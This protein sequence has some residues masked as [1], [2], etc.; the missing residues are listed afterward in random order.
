MKEKLNRR[1]HLLIKL[2]A[3]L[4]WCFIPISAYS[5]ER[6]VTGRVIDKENQEPIP[7]VSIV[8]E[9][10]S[11]GTITDMDGN[12][13]LEVDGPDTKMTFSFIGFEAQTVEVGTQQQI[14]ISLRPDIVDLD[15]V[16]VVGYGT[17]KKRD[18]TGAVASVKGSSMDKGSPVSM[19]SALAGRVAGVQVTQTDNGPGAGVK[20]LIRGGSTLTGGNQPLYVIDGFP[21]VPDDSNPN[22]NPLADLNPND[23]ESM[24]ILKDASSTAIYGAEGANG[25]II[26]TT[27]LGKA[28]RPSI[29]VN[30]SYGL[31]EMTNV[32][33]ILSPDE[34][35]NW[36]IEKGP[37][38]QFY[39]P[40]VY[41]G[42]WQ[43][44]KDSG[45]PGN[46][47]ID[48]IT[49]QGETHKA[50]VSFSGGS[51][52]M[53]YRLS[54]SYLG[55]EGVL[56]NS[57]FERFNLNANLEQEI[58]KRIKIG[59]S[60][61]YSKAESNGMVNSWDESAVVK[62][63][64]QINPFMPEDY[65]IDQIDEEAET[66]TW[67]NENVLTYMD[68]VDI[69]SA[70]ERMIG[71]MFFQYKIANGLNFYT[72]YGLNSFSDDSHEFYPSSVRRGYRVGGFANFRN[73]K[74][75]NT[76]YQARFNFNKRVNDHSF[77]VTTVFEAKKF[78]MTDKRFGAEGFEDESRGV[79]DLSSVVTPY[80]PSNIYSDNSMMSYMGRL[81]Y[82]YKGK[83]LLTASFRAD[84]SS[85][86]GENNKWGY[87]PSAAI[88]WLASEEGF[89]KD[90]NTFDLLKLRLSYGVTGNN[91]I[92]TYQSLANLSTEKY[93]FDESVYVGMVPGRIANPDLKW[94]TTQQY[95]VGMDLGFF[96]NRLLV[97]AE[98]YYKET[99]D[100]LLEVQ[101]PNTSG[102]NTAI[103]N[104]GSISNKGFELAINTVNIDNKDFKWTT[105][106]TYSLNRSEVLDLGER[107]E[108]FFSRKFYH[109]IED[110]VVIRV[111]EPVGRFYG[112]IED[113]VL[114]SENEIANSPDM[115][116]LENEVGQVKLKDVNGDGV[117]T[118]ADK[119]LIG[120]T[121]P[122]F[123]G[124]LNNEF[125][126]KN[127][128]LSFFLRWS[129]G[130]DV[131]NG[132]VSFLDRVGRGN[133][134]TLQG[135][136]DHAYSPLN[137]EGTVHGSVPDTY[138][139]LMRS[140]YVE[141]GSF[142]KCDYITLGYTLPKPIL[143]RVNVNKLRVFARVDNPFMITRYSWYDP[144]V[145]T[146]WGTVA[147]VG[148]GVDLGSY[149]RSTTYTLG[150]SISF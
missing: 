41:T 53:Q 17:M 124:G 23:I 56:Q 144:E 39:D 133:W 139:N 25:V 11:T 127:F 94:E 30:Y 114:N 81:G 149:P 109:K 142:L 125:N 79:Y 122:D 26:I 128:D 43:Q 131:I 130:N 19:Q 55:Q 96:K 77:N 3:I 40:T 138:S 93:V 120:N 1:V 108:M 113:E 118:P 47:W 34:Y 141:D 83:Y 51:E 46:V 65:D 126:Y 137:P 64:F 10:T 135:Y 129:Y 87:F 80:F 2:S 54:G 42:A 105:A 35:L 37:I 58:G 52:G 92:P 31:S 117:V 45:Q 33:N 134:N 28:G 104:V 67:N 88:G 27:K 62:T 110:E 78:E 4:L 106:F 74:M 36:Q 72:S 86:F 121:T 69:S 107:D 75:L 119:V 14:D 70:T 18:L 123:I 61:K 111:G 29:D 7:G 5:Q 21:I 99:N 68:E 97:T 116:M 66:Y 115:V 147:K 89:I 38:T 82:N 140:S 84:G 85:K 90:L 24:E 49:R 20:V 57:D 148:P 73:R 16:V 22:Q 101:L 60:L 48:R 50:D 6:V 132:N 32:P 59:A 95:N 63:A 112:Y 103:Q 136:A 150:A 15:E 91:Q 13:S 76:A 146:G 8:I 143:T 100:L 98:A 102:F 44:I 9:G 71:N 12:Y 145:S